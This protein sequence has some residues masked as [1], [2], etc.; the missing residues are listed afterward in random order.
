MDFIVELPVSKDCIQ[1]LIIMDNFIKMAQ[2]IL[3]KD[4]LKKAPDLVHSFVNEIWLH[5]RL[6]INIISNRDWRIVYSS[7]S[8]NYLRKLAL[9][10][11]LVSS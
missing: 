7:I 9:A 3:L 10:N 8:Y 2:C 4:N 6:L 5:H 1:I 11:K